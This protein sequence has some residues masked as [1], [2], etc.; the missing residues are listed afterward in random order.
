M[1]ALPTHRKQKGAVLVLVTVALFV[2]LGFTALAL[3]GGYLL[4]NKTRVQDAVDSAALS[5]AKTLSKTAANGNTHDDAR[6]AVY[7]TLQTIFNGDG[8]NQ[9]DIDTNNIAAVTTIEFSHKAVPF[10]VTNDSVA[11]YIRVRLNTVPVEQFLSQLMVDNWRVASAAVA[12]PEQGGNSVEQQ[13]IPLLLCSKDTSD[14]HHG[15][16]PSD[17]LTRGDVIVVKT[18]HHKKAPVGPGNFLALSLD[19]DGDGSPD[20]GANDFAMALSGDLNVN[21][22]I[23]AGDVLTTEPGNMVGKTSE[24]LNTRF[25][26]DKHGNDVSGP[27]AD[28]GE[29]ETGAYYSDCAIPDFSGPV[30]FSDLDFGGDVANGGNLVL[31]QGSDKWSGLQSFPDYYNGIHSKAPSTTHCIDERRIVK[32][33]VANCDGNSTGRSNI[34]VMD[35][36]CMFLNQEVTGQ[37]NNQYIVAEMLE[38]CDLGGGS[39]GSNTSERLVLY[40][41]SASGDS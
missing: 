33:P 35:T 30:T 28:P 40:K 16:T 12:G 11:R 8:F 18:N 25:G 27:S 1:K 7:N 17:D 36:V 38:S 6:A 13:V 26:K 19:R 21:S 23:E 32:L 39:G 9:V 14:D 37:G 31:Q 34:S 24:G 3:D 29:S 41:D 10:V 20:T 2:L 4:L 5:G 15:F 22:V